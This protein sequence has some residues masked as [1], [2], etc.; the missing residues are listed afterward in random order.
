MSG[1]HGRERSRGS[2]VPKPEAGAPE[3]PAPFGKGSLGTGGL[4]TTTPCPQAACPAGA[5]TSCPFPRDTDN[6]QSGDA[7]REGTFLITAW[8]TA[9]LREYTLLSGAAN[10]MGAHVRSSSGAVGAQSS[11]AH[12]TPSSKPPTRPGCLSGVVP[13]RGAPA[14]QTQHW[15]CGPSRQEMTNFKTE[16][17]CAR[18]AGLTPSL[19]HRLPSLPHFGSGGGREST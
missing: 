10:C 17:S 1:P 14:P 15:P 6:P 5:Q 2:P 4:A 12:S 3:S 7:T 19:L 18:K 13:L 11:Q 16:I 8:G 9:V